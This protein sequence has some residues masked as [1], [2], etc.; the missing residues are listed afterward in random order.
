VSQNQLFFG[1]NLDILREHIKD[2]TVDLDPPFNSKRDYSVLFKTPKYP[3]G[4]RDKKKGADG[5]ID[6]LSF[7]ADDKSSMKKIVI[8]V[9]G[10]ENVSFTMIRDL[11]RVIDREKATI[12]LFVTLAEP[13]RPMKE[14]AISLGLYDSERFGT[15]YPKHQTLTIE[16]LMAGTERPRFS[17]LTLDRSTFKRAQ[18]E[19]MG[20]EQGKMF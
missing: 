14:E 7:F 20:G 19:E 18:V 4:A 3:C 8:S 10:G 17:D 2:E 5:G 12:G 15:E 9:R 6:G 13:T 1:D 11:A 16:G